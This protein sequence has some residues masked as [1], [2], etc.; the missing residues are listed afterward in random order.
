[1]LCVSISFFLAHFKTPTANYVVKNHIDC[2][3]N[4]AIHGGFVRSVTK[5]ILWETL[6]TLNQRLVFNLS[7]IRRETNELIAM[8]FY[9]NVYTV[10]DYSV[11]VFEKTV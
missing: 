2:K 4:N 3:S 9:T 8:H 1:M 5:R 11:I 7:L 10:D 6:M